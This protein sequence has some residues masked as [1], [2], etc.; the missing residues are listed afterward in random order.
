[1]YKAG[2][3]AECGQGTMSDK[4]SA[5]RAKSDA[6]RDRQ[7]TSP[8]GRGGGSALAV[9]LVGHRAMAMLPP[10]ALPVHAGAR[11]FMHRTSSTRH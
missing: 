10:R 7:R 8:S 4:S 2:R 11:D 6:D 1:M 9:L 3:L 5:L